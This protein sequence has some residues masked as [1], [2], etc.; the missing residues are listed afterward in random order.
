MASLEIALQMRWPE[1]HVSWVRPGPG[2][3]KSA[4]QANPDLV[5]V[6]P[7]ALE[8]GGAELVT[9]MRA[10]FGGVIIVLSG[11]PSEKE[12]LEVIDA[13]ADD[14]L[15]QGAS[16]AQLV[17]RIHALMRPRGGGYQSPTVARCGSLTIDVERHSAQVGGKEL[18]LTPTEFTLLNHLAQNGGKIVTQEALHRLIWGCDGRIFLD[19]LRK[20]VERLR[21][22][23]NGADPDVR[24]VSVPRV[25]YKLVGPSA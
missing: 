11:E 24:I 6:G 17:A 12:L 25:G 9:D 16:L 14:Y 2:A 22:R 23:L 13:G 1:H 20:Y 7:I 3:T 18:Y 21:K 8:Q 15:P 5:V 4:C 10:G 19:S